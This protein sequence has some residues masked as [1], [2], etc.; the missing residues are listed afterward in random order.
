MRTDSVPDIVPMLHPRLQIGGATYILVT[1][2]AATV[3]V[4][5][6]GSVAASLIAHEYVINRAVDMLTT[7]F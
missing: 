4:R 1:H 6:F 5:E 2:L 7:G 3:P